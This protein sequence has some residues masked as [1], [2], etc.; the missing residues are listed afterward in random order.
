M[1]HSEAQSK[2]DTVVATL[3]EVATVATV[4]D[5]A[6]THTV[7]REVATEASSHTAVAPVEAT[8]VATRVVAIRLRVATEE[9]LVATPMRGPSSWATSASTARKAM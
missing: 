3:M 2:E 8:E 1:I 5:M 7:D 6:T 4:V 9:V